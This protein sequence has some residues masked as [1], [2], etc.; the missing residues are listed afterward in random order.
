M[1]G[2]FLAKRIK[3]SIEK[4]VKKS[5]LQSEGLEPLLQELKLTL[6]DS[7]VN[8]EVVKKIISD[9]RIKT[10]NKNLIE[11]LSPA[12]TVIKIV[13]E[14][15]KN[16]LGNTTSKINI[17]KNPTVILIAGLQ[18]SGKTT[19]SAKLASFINRKDKKNVLLVACDIYRPAAIE[20]LKI[21]AEK[22]KVG[23]FEKGKQDPILTAKE[24]L[25]Y[26][27]ENNY[28]CVIIDTAGRLQIDEKLM[29][30]IQQIKQITSPSETLLVLDGMIGQEVINVTKEFNKKISLTGV[31]VTK[32]DGDTR[33]GAT[34]SISYL[35]NVPIK[36]IGTGEGIFNIDIFH[37]KRM[38][39]RIL[40]M[41][42]V[43]TLFEKL[44]ENI[45]ERTI[46]TTMRRMMSGQFDLQDYLNQLKQMKSMG[47][48]SGI[49]K[50]FPG[51]NAISENKADEITQ[52]L[53]ITEVILSSTTIKERRE[54]R[55]LKHMTRKQR[56]LKGSGR[57][58]KEFN[59]LINQ[60]EKIKKKVDEIRKQ[61][62]SGR[63]PNF[64]NMSNFLKN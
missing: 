35:T 54:P 29:N 31:I 36:F 18:G 49:L 9:I 16:I 25:H 6:L 63:M 58:E 61:L 2:D 23:F 44:Q 50:L 56:I 55:L 10:E 8:I 46:K 11:N 40:G 42:D 51:A 57:T 17:S 45:D 13:H 7:D 15:I 38:A 37:P 4:K 20:Q 3:K 33:G 12:Q 47:S 5:I 48:I 24:S 32:L 43:D 27:K 62:A 26:A 41:G 21:L 28:D 19:T 53:F 14:E 64:G 59:E 60:F 52:K 22:A 39:D 30:E 1:I 34:L